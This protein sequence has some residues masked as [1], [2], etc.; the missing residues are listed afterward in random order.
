VQANAYPTANTTSSGRTLYFG[1]VAP[2]EVGQSV[3]GI[4]E[5]IMKKARVS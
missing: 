3:S 5:E 4:G 2:F 1:N